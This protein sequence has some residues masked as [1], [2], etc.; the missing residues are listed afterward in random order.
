M[1]IRSFLAFEL[2]I[3]I[4][5]MISAVS[6]NARKTSLDVRWV[7]AA[8]IHLTIVFMGSVPEEHIGSIGN[9]VRDVCQGYGPFNI[10]AK[11]LGLFGSRRNPRV[12]WIGLGGDIDR[13]S[14]FRNDLQKGLKPFGIKEEKRRFSPHLTLGRFRKG[15]KTGAHVDDLLSKYQDLK[16]PECKLNQLVLFKSDLKP[17]G[18]VYTRLGAWPLNG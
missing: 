2:P 18:A 6:E 1:E 10:M 9:S 15:A 4:K 3:E 16:S 14:Y 8:N 12:L 13:M 17:G 5:N 7:N 11:G